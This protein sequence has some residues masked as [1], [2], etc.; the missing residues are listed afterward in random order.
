MACHVFNDSSAVITGEDGLIIRTDNFGLGLKKASMPQL[1]L[2]VYPNP[3]Y[4]G[5]K[6]ITL[7]GLTP[8]STCQITLFDLHGNQVQKV[9]SG[10][11]ENSELQLRVDLSDLAAGS[12]VYRVQT[13]MGVV[14]KKVVVY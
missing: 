5:F 8:Q 14:Q 9:Y 13:E 1:G 6:N 4:N 12:Y 10:R 2:S 11:T 3:T 7:T